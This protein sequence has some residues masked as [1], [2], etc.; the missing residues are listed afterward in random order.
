VSEE[1]HVPAGIPQH[2]RADTGRLLSDRAAFCR[3][4]RIKH[5]QQQKFVPFEP[6]RAQQALWDLMDKTNRVIVIKARQV[7]ISTAVRAWQFH[8]AYS[9]PNPETYAVLSFHER[10]ARNLRR[11]DR[12]WL[13]ELPTL[14]QRELDVDSAE[15]TVFKDTLAG[16]SS[17]TTGGRGGTRSFEFTGG[18]LSEFAFYTDADEVLAQT[19]STVGNGPVI[20]ESTVNAPGDAFHRLIE[21]APENGWTVFSYWWW[22]HD[23]YRD[24]RVPEEFEPTLEEE[25]LAEKYGLDEAQLWWRRQQVATLGTH[26]FKREY[27]GCLDDAFL[28]RECT[29]F[30]PRD[31]DQI[32]TVWFDT[33]QREFAPPEESS[34]YVMGVDVAAGVGQDYSALSVI[35]LGSLQPVYIE[36]SNTTSPVDFAARVATVARRYNGALVLCEANNH[37]HVV[38]NELNRLRYTNLWKNARGKP[39]ITTVRSKLDAFEC[40]REHVKAGI[41]FALDQSTMHELRGL[42]VRRVTP[43]A[44]AGLHDDLAV[45]LALAYRCVRSAPLAHRRESMT[46]YMDEFIR[47]RR[48]ARIKSR[49]LPW[50]TNT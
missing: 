19:I 5:K 45:S 22:Q 35:E 9:S 25:E 29:Y 27:P 13:T 12:R 41:I 50:S 8:R 23:A 26:K 11:M 14:L 7:G 10:S 6:N 36:R 2:L 17:F 34:R 49:A 40:L 46:G 15:D 30:D 47:S 42:E 3:M 20:I 18:H 32:D 21:G 37:G 43:E 38:L 33:P 31:L 4:I 39:W 48:V 24:E 1:V 28:A 16:F 44:P